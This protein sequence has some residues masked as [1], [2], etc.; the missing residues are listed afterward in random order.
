MPQSFHHFIYLA[1]AQFE[2]PIPFQF[3]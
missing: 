3:I 2:T 1:K